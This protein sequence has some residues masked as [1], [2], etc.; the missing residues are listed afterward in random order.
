[1]YGYFRVIFGVIGDFKDFF[2][3]IVV[4]LWIFY[5]NFLIAIFLGN[6]GVIGDIV[7]EFLGIL[8]ILG[9][10]WGNLG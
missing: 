8:G 5:W 4:I 3:V 10:I 1:M 7:D 6:F 9:R 2:I